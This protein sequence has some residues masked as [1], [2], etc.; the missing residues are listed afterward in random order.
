MGR[1][2][3]TRSTPMASRV[4]IRFMSRH[5]RS[6]VPIGQPV[7][8]PRSACRITLPRSACAMWYVSWESF[9]RVALPS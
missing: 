5:R 2:Y 3:N 9:T 6:A 1:G 8:S 7:T 4:A